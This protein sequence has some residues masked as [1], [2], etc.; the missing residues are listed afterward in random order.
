M[1]GG[2]GRKENQKQRQ[3]VRKRGKM[4]PGNKKKVKGAMAGDLSGGQ[5]NFHK[6][7]HS[8]SSRINNHL[9]DRDLDW[10]WI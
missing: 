4:T 7:L 6:L 10:I 5:K 1:R 2:E 8:D 3:S 9:L